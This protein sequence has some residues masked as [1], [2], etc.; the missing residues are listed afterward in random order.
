LVSILQLV[1]T[2]NPFSLFL[3]EIIKKNW[4]QWLAETRHSH[5]YVG[6]REGRMKKYQVSKAATDYQTEVSFEVKR[7][8][9]SLPGL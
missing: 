1:G 2:G 7:E 3:G 9:D 4:D 8:E 6:V 5:K